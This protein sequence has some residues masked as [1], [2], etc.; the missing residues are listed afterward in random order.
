MSEGGLIKDSRCQEALDFL[1]SK[2]LPDGGWPAE[3]RYYKVTEDVDPKPNRDKVAWG[4]NAKKV[5]NEWVTA[6]A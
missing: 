3:G 2:E 5:M 4:S 6:D 1:E